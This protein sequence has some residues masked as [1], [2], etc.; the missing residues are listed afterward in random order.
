MITTQV[1]K[2]LTTGALTVMPDAYPI[3]GDNQTGDPEEPVTSH[4][5]VNAKVTRTRVELQQVKSSTEVATPDVELAEGLVEATTIGGVLCAPKEFKFDETFD[6]MKKRQALRQ[7]GSYVSGRDRNGDLQLCCGAWVVFAAGVGWDNHWDD[8]CQK[9]VKWM[10]FL[11]AIALLGMV[12]IARFQ[13]TH[14]GTI[15]LK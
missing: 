4:I 6:I 3:P 1:S 14:G 8:L 2:A 13:S 11:P 5:E 12:F 15:L 10:F 9:D 7:Q